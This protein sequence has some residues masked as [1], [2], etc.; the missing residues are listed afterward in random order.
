MDPAITSLPAPSVV[1]FLILNGVVSPWAVAERVV[2]YRGDT[3]DSVF[4]GLPRWEDRIVVAQW[5]R[6]GLSSVQDGGGSA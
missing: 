1:K 4:V 2:K 3:G 5:A 6:L